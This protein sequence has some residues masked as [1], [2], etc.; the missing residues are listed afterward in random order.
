MFPPE[1]LFSNILKLF[2]I[3]LNDMRRRI[4][5]QF[6]WYYQISK[7][8]LQTLLKTILSYELRIMI[9][10]SLHSEKLLHSYIKKSY[11]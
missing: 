4:I 3:V 9:G 1:H 11:A 10:L 7:V 5:Y 2:V 6:I 8:L